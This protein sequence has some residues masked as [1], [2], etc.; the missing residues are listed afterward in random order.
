MPGINADDREPSLASSV[1]SPCR[2]RSCLETDPDR[3]RRVG[4]QELRYG[5][6]IGSHHCLPL[7]LASL[8]NDT[9][10]G[11]LQRNIQSNIVLHSPLR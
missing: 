4:G 7:D 6:R 11:L 8:I 3:V 1:Q 5:V 9:H 10:G 2:C